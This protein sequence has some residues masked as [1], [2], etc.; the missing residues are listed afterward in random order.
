MPAGSI[1][2]TNCTTCAAPGRKHWLCTGSTRPTSAAKHRQ[3]AAWLCPAVGAEQHRLGAPPLA[4]PDG[5]DVREVAPVQGNAL[6]L[7][8]V[9]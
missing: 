2:Q 4:K 5:H 1:P 7:Q 8:E 6:H 9:G 3:Q